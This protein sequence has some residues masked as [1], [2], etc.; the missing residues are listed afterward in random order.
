MSSRPASASPQKMAEVFVGRT[1]SQAQIN[2]VMGSP[3]R[4]REGPVEPPIEE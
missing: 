2:V 3:T 1:V 4:N